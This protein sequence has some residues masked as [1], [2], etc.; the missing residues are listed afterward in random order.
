MFKMLVH[1]YFYAL[2]NSAG[3]PPVKIRYFEK[4]QFF[5]I[6]IEKNEK[7]FEILKNWKLRDKTALPAFLQKLYIYSIMSARLTLALSKKFSKKNTSKYFCSNILHI[8]YI[9]F[10]N[11][12]CWW[13]TCRVHPLTSL[14]GP[15][16]TLTST[17]TPQKLDTT[18]PIPKRVP[19]ITRT[20]PNREKFRGSEY[21]KLRVGIFF[22]KV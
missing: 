12:F 10:F 17:M 20:S 8:I 1:F 18:P 9:I 15:Y 21:H 4:F 14:H 19:E 5:N 7:I 6:L 11:F 13:K 2:C 16:L 3:F 22:E